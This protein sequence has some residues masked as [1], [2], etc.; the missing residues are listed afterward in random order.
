MLFARTTTLLFGA[1]A[2]CLLPA[3][4]PDLPGSYFPSDKAFAKNGNGNGNSNGNGNG[5]GNGKNGGNAGGSNGNSGATATAQIPTAAETMGTAS[6]IMAMATSR[7][8]L[9][10]TATARVSAGS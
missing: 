8:R 2:L 4:S 7:K 6:S 1:A 10:V 5:N 3:L 9:P